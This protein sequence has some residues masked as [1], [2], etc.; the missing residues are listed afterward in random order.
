MPVPPG[1]TVVEPRVPDPKEN[2][3]AMAALG[4]KPSAR[5]KRPRTLLSLHFRGGMCHIAIAQGR[6]GG[7]FNPKQRSGEVG[8][9]RDH[10]RTHAQHRPRG[11]H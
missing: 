1:A 5:V 2:P 10:T 3:V 8:G 7:K 6:P 4:A 11:K 9:G